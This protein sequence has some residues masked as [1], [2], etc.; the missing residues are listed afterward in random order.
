MDRTVIAYLDEELTPDKQSAGILD[1]PETDVAVNAFRLDAEDRSLVLLRH[2]S[3]KELY[4][5]PFPMF[6][7]IDLSSTVDDR[8]GCWLIVQV[9]RPMTTHGIYK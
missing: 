8:N 3:Q 7:H 4:Y 5:L 2:V 6:G 9:Q 1:C